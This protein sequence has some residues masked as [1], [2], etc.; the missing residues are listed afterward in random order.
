[1]K[2]TVFIS[3]ELEAD[4]NAT[5]RQHRLVLRGLGENPDRT[6]L[7]IISRRDQPEALVKLAAELVPSRPERLVVTDASAGSLPRHALAVW[8]ACS[9]AQRVFCAST[10]DLPLAAVAVRPGGCLLVLVR[11]T[12]LGTLG[13][14]RALALR[15]CD[16][17]LCDNVFTRDTLAARFPALAERLRVTSPAFSLPAVNS[18]PPRPPPVGEPP[19]VLCPTPLHGRAIAA[20]EQA[21]HVFARLPTAA[22]H[23][24]SALMPR[25]RFCGVGPGIERLLRAA[26]HDH[27]EDRVDFRPARD[28]AELRAAYASA[29]CCLLPDPAGPDMENTLDALSSG[30]PCVAFADG[31]ASELLS[32]RNAVLADDHDPAALSAALAECLV[33][34]RDTDEIWRDVQAFDYTQLRSTLLGVWS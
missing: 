17:I 30:R 5:V 7:W 28:L 10:A 15:R 23:G 27:V 16:R 3:P 18:P 34:L 13:P 26:R 2:R 11:D 24:K 9:G 19:L 8:H 31:A 4:L 32:P 25:L 12:D 22:F 14:L 29:A 1:M 20:A 33:R 21:V 6:L